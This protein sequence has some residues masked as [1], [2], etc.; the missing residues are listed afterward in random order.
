MNKIMNKLKKLVQEAIE[1][2]R[3]VEVEIDKPTIEPTT[4]VEE[5]NIIA[6]FGI[7]KD[8]TEVSATEENSFIDDEGNQ[9][10]FSISMVLQ[11][12]EGEEGIFLSKSQRDKGREW[13]LRIIDDNLEFILINEN[14]GSSI[15]QRIPTR[16]LPSDKFSMVINSIGNKS[17]SGNEFS[18]N[19]RRIEAN[20][21]GSSTFSG[22]VKTDAPILST[23]NGWND[24]SS[25]IKIYSAVIEK[26][27]TL[28][29]KEIIE[30]Y[31]ENFPEN[32]LFLSEAEDGK[33]YIPVEPNTGEDK[34]IE[35][36]EA[37]YKVPNDSKVDIEVGHYK[38]N[39]LEANPLET[40]S[41]IHLFGKDNI[42]IDGNHSLL[43]TTVHSSESKEM[44][45]AKRI[46]MQVVDSN[47]IEGRNINILG[48]F[49]SQG[50][51]S[52]K[53]FEHGI[54]NSGCKNLKYENITVKNVGGDGLYV[55]HSDNILFKNIRCSNINRQGIAAANGTTNLVID[56]LEAHGGMRADIDLEPQNVNA[57]IDGV[58]IKNCYLTNHIAAA[59]SGKINN[60]NIHHNRYIK[61]IIMKGGFSY[62]RENWIIEDNEKLGGGGSP[63]A[64][65]RVSV[66]TN[67]KI[68]RNN[69][70][71]PTAQG[72]W[73]ISLAYCSGRIEIKNNK[74][75]NPCINRI[76]NCPEG[77]EVII[78]EPN[79]DNIYIVEIGGRREVIGSNTELLD[80]IEELGY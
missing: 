17:V 23:I 61:S 45:A 40:H 32:D 53:A 26:D 14:D 41:S 55:D 49:N 4:P 30:H 79:S 67:V 75:D 38:V 48:A 10:P 35:L 9:V 64:M 65:V 20:H 11:I 22:I 69:I 21:I 8:Y 80:K 13:M 6:E 28:S 37:F 3:K 57:L 12:P 70:S 43:Y 52:S 46:Q 71:V 24:S 34:G 39:M 33:I 18:V 59:G 76:L 62:P 58:E 29:T 27:R 15:I 19:T 5:R 51:D 47:N 25:N 66:C 74:Y 50:Y 60:V 7:D 73:G 1:A 2:L 72:R 56:N 78:D 68:N 63:M 77:T 54:S 42:A 44:G 16:K 36:K 31:Q